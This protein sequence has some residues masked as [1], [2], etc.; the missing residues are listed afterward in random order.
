MV[1][2]FIIV[3]FVNPSPLCE[4]ATSVLFAGCRCAMSLIILI[5]VT[6]VIR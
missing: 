6:L 4:V 5:R 1:A 3:V 2:I